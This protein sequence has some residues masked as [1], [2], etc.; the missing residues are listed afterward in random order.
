VAG[1]DG[2]L[3]VVAAQLAEE[4]DQLV[5]PVD[6]LHHVH[7]RAQQPASL[8]RH[9]GREQIAAIGGDHEQRAVEVLRQFVGFRLDLRKTFTNQ[10]GHLSTIHGRNGKRLG[11]GGDLHGFST[12][13]E[14]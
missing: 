9:G 5:G 3:A 6:H 7:E 8:G 4:G 11:H 1:D 2:E 10:P 14:R 12:H 13:R